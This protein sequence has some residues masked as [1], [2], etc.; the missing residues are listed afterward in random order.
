MSARVQR[1]LEDGRLE[2]AATL[3]GECH[4]AD[5]GDLLPLLEYED[6]SAGGLMRREFLSI[7]SGTTASNGLDSL[8]LLLRRCDGRCRSGSIAR[9][10]SGPRRGLRRARYHIDRRTRLPYAARL[11]SPSRDA[12][13][14][15]PGS[16]E[17]KRS[18]RGRM[19]GLSD[20]ELLSKIRR[21][22]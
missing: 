6:D 21:K 11:G 1:L 10:Q 20:I 4:H 15:I 5:Q 2:E 3:F 7:S 9:A 19:P 16:W 14:L 18:S 22:K 8:R 12:P 17:A 13:G